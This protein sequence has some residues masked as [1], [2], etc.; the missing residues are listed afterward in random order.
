MGVVF[1]AKDLKLKRTVALKFLPE[2]YSKHP[3]PL[4]RFHQEARAAAALNHPNIC[5]IYEIGE[6][7]SRPFIA[8][9]LLEGQTLKDLLAERPLALDELLELATQIAGALDAAHRRGI[10]H[11]DVK[12]AN[13]FVTRSGQV[14]ILDFG[15]A[16]LAAG[17]SLNTLQG[18]IAEDSAVSVTAAPGSPVGTVAYMSPEH[19]RGADVDSRSDIF[20][21]GVVLYEMAAGRR[22]F[23]AESPAETMNAILNDDSP[24]LPDSVPP[25]VN[26]IVRRCLEKQPGQRFQSAAELVMAL[27][28]VSVLEETSDSS[29]QL[30]RSHGA[31]RAWIAATALL[32]ML[33]VVMAVLDLREKTAK[34]PAIQFSVFPPPGVK[35]GEVRYEGPPLISPDGS[36]LVFGGID[37]HGKHQLWVRPLNSLAAGPLPETEGAF[38]PFWS[39]DSRWLAFFVGRKLKKIPID[40]GQAQTLANAGCCGGTWARAGN[41]AGTIVF[42]AEQGGGLQRMAAEGG[43][44][45]Q[46][47]TVDLTRR[48]RSHCHP[49]FLPDGRHFLFLTVNDPEDNEAVFI[50]DAQSKPDP[51][52]LNRVMGGTSKAWWAPPGY[53]LFLRDNNLMAHAFDAGRLRLT[54]QPFLIAEH[55]GHGFN[56]NTSDFSVSANGVLA[57]RAGF[58]T[59]RQLAW[60]DR[61]GRRLPGL[62]ISEPYLAPRLSPD[63]DRLAFI[64]LE[65]PA[66]AVQGTVAESSLTRNVWLLDLKRG[67]QTPLAFGAAVR[68]VWSP[69]GRRVVFGRNETRACGLFWKPVSGGNDE[70][71]LLRTALKPIPLSWSHDGRFLLFVQTIAGTTGDLFSLPLKDGG[72]PILIARNAADGEFSPDGRWIAYVSTESGAGQIV[73][74]PFQ[75]GKTAAEKFA[76][77]TEKGW[78]P[79]WRGDGRE[80]FYYGSFERTLVAIPVNAAGKFE[81][82]TPVELF[83]THD[84]DPGDF[85]YNVSADGQRF[86]ISRIVQDDNRPINISLNW[87]VTAKH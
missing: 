76:V 10:V 69:D 14:K 83:D 25:A 50:A 16:K 35:F 57:W 82:G 31:P 59:L 26:R 58:N 33:L 39:P 24:E 15:L 40:G 62:D 34:P 11:R 66:V 3:Q 73:V 13:I 47:T 32:A 77:S 27:R 18:A 22:A 1:R 23:A 61:S 5:I 60:F 29:N 64:R 55:V 81:A 37:E 49:Q 44:P 68:P 54:G 2:E 84:A 30:K 21:M 87:L 12:P 6:E 8:M 43:E 46:I 53:L 75:D 70:E 80:L 86:L 17:H 72:H 79:R 4:E 41:G 65:T 7:H 78:E 28:S 38:Y 48:E 56:R 52:N 9:E 74:R 19:V 67:L 36:Q 20:S 85:D 42:P 71:L 51:K 63:G 45:V